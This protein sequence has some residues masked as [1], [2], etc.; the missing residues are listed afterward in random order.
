[1]PDSAVSSTNRGAGAASGDS[2]L[3]D[4]CAESKSAPT[5]IRIAAGAATDHHGT[6]RLGLVSADAGDAIGFDV[7][8]AVDSRAACLDPHIDAV[9]WQA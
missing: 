9:R 4:P 3:S 1:M 2:E 7:V 5:P 6:W 8:I